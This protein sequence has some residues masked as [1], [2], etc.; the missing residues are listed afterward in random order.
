MI[1]IE[2][3][4]GTVLEFPDGTSRE[5]I[6][7]VGR[8]M[9][10]QRR[11]GTTALSVVQPTIM[12]APAPAPPVAAPVAPGTDIAVAPPVAPD[13]PPVAPATGGLFPPPAE[14][15]PI[16]WPEAAPRVPEGVRT[17]EEAL[18]LSGPMDFSAVPPGQGIALAGGIIYYPNEQQWFRSRPDLPEEQQML[19]RAAGQRRADSAGGLAYEIAASP[20]AA[21]YMMGFSGGLADEGLG[22]IDPVAGTALQQA[23]QQNRAENPVRSGVGEVAG[24][25]GGAV[26]ASR[27]PGVPAVAGVVS[28]AAGNNL[29]R[30]AAVYGATGGLFNTLY[31]AATADTGERADAAT[32]PYNAAFGV[33]AGAA[34]PVVARGMGAASQALGRRLEPGMPE[35]YP[36]GTLDDLVPVPSPYGMAPVTP[37]STAAP[38]GQDVQDYLNTLNPTLDRAERVLM[39]DAALDLGVDLP[40]GM[41]TNPEA[42][43]RALNETTLFARGKTLQAQNHLREQLSDK[44]GGIVTTN[45]PPTSLGVAGDRLKTSAM[46]NIERQIGNM[47]EEYTA[48]RTRLSGEHTLPINV[49]DTL[50]KVFAKR[51]DA[52]SPLDEDDAFISEV[53]NLV[54]RNSVRDGGDPDNMVGVTWEGM[55]DARTA[56]KV[57]MSNWS[58]G[59]RLTPKQQHMADMEDALTD[60]MA[61]IV[62]RNAPEGQGQA[63]VEQFYDL[64]RRY[65]IAQ[66]ARR[67]L[68]DMFTG[69]STS[70]MNTLG[71]ALQTGGQSAKDEIRLLRGNSAQSDWDNARAVLLHNMGADDLG[72]FDPSR[73]ATQWNKVAPDV[74]EEV[75]DKAHLADLDA[76]ARISRNIPKPAPGPRASTVSFGTL[77]LPVASAVTGNVLP[78]VGGVV[79]HALRVV[80]ARSLSNPY[81]ANQAKRLYQG[82]DA[83]GKAKTDAARALQTMKA[84]RDL[85]SFM[86]NT[87][88]SYKPTVFSGGN[89]A[90]ETPNKVGSVGD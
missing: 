46:A 69:G 67:D 57:Q 50:D 28:N 21:G 32:D 4:D 74:R 64:D 34:G 72:Q 84:E 89:A 78:A 82:L 36:A 76:I 87:D 39:G 71:K 3:Y 25:V 35:I 12:P 77:S 38:L 55:Q 18:A 56:L 8:N 1:E 16:L 11:A 66:K 81:V 40:R 31:G 22:L 47:G 13:T 68:N 90:S 51:F 26:T 7:N 62:R 17:L 14:D 60:A 83:V 79:A 42:Y 2:L 58:R 27:V 80:R 15:E 86:R 23:Y 19:E 33:A 48:L 37:G 52:G 10:L 59:Q 85:D 88:P 6:A 30:Q 24:A 53:A 43:E 61:T 45:Q 29:A 44:F 20:E 41:V 5:V 75:F 49:E 63:A 73:F 9:T 70:V 65:A 54:R